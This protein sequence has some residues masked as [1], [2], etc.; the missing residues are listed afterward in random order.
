MYSRAHGKRHTHPETQHTHKYKC[1]R[2]SQADQTDTRMCH[3]HTG[4]S[5]CLAISPPRPS[6]HTR[7][8]AHTC[9]HARALS[10]SGLSPESVVPPPA[11]CSLVSPANRGRGN[12]RAAWARGVPVAEMHPSLQ[13][14]LP[15]CRLPPRAQRGIRIRAAWWGLG[16]LPAA[17]RPQGLTGRLAT[18]PLSPGRGGGTTVT[19][20]SSDRQAQRTKLPPGPGRDQPGGAPEGR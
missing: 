9:A 3:V 20:R 6:R 1:T 18:W 17:P 15:G 16:V 13:A 14:R 12:T 4:T 19:G 11:P 7:T 8:R 2:R 10:A 5:S